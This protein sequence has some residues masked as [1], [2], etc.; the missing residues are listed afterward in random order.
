M[1]HAAPQHVRP[2]KKSAPPANSGA[3]ASGAGPGA[4]ATIPPDTTPPPV[5]TEPARTPA[6]ADFDEIG[7]LNLHPDIAAAVARGDVLSGWLHYHLF[8]RTE[9]R[10]AHEL[11]PAFYLAAYP[12]ARADIAAGLAPDPLTHF[13]Q[14]GRARGYLPNLRAT[15]PDHAASLPSRFGGLW[16]DQPNARDI[17][18]GKLTIGRITPDEAAALDHYIIHGYVVLPQALAGALARAAT[19]ALNSAFRGAFPALCFETSDTPPVFC[20]WRRDLD[21]SGARALDIHQA[22]P[23]IRDAMFAP[24][25]AAF[26]GLVFDA[27]LLAGHT[28]GSTTIAARQ[29]LPDSPGFALS[30]PR[31]GASAMLALDPIPA[32]AGLVVYPGSH[33]FP[34]FLYDGR[35]KTITEV[36]RLTGTSSRLHDQMAVH[37]RAVAHRIDGLGI[38][39]TP[40]VMAAGDVLI[41]NLDLVYGAN[42]AAGMGAHRHIVAKYSPAYAAPLVMERLPTNLGRHGVHLYTAGPATA[43]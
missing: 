13:V 34:D 15:R 3:K 41:R 26:L 35:C 32:A 9:G 10:R 22:A 1:S 30:L 25:I 40:L 21:Q 27:P 43:A 31:A 38:A 37:A 24:A 19:D 4:A 23:A 20:T 16:T 8:G 18:R 2:S 6:P 36:Q 7:Y 29:A 42:P 28:A 12:V 17:A 11:D 39:A 5:L 33:R 14:F